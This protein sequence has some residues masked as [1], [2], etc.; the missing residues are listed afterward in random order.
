MSR[1]QDVMKDWFQRVWVDYDLDAIDE[2]FQQDGQ[3]QGIMPD[4][5]LGSSDFKD[6]VPMVQELLDDIQVDMTMMTQTDQ[7]V[8]GLYRVRA[9]SSRDSAPVNAMGQLCA[10]FENGRIVEAYNTFDFFNF[11][12]QLGQLPDMSLALCLSGE[13]LS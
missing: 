2:L 10:R 9:L 3:A 1:E 4:M 13:K 8:Q 11:F 5:A 6:F 7:W 12:E